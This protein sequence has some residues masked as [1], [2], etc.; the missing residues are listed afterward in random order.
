MPL[1]LPHAVTNLQQHLLVA[2]ATLDETDFARSIIFVAHHDANGS[3]GFMINQPMPRLGFADVARSMGIEEILAQAREH[4]ILY[5]GG[6]VESTRGFVLHSTDYSLK[7]SVKLNGDFTLSAQ[8]DIVADIAK[9]VGPRQL[10][11]CLGYAGWSAGQLEQEL[12]TNDWLILPA[13]RELVF[14]VP[15][16]Q[17]YVHATRML[18]LNPLNFPGGIVGQ[19]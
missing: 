19:A 7:S 13:T 6:P 2:T 18:G 12:V 3:M 4:P 10:N 16:Q 15:P 5:K 14:E 1:Q 9:G 11:F 17:R 8:A